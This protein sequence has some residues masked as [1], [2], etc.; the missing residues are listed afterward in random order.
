MV[1]N[2]ASD[3]HPC[4]PSKIEKG[5]FGLTRCYLSLKIPYEQILNTEDLDRDVRV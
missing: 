3:L 1:C 5:G 2:A 4:T